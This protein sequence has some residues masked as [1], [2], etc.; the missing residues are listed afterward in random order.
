M[1]TILDR[2]A[3]LMGKVIVP[4][5]L[6]NA[7]DLADAERGYINSEQV[8]SIEVEAMID[9]GAT[10]VCLA[11][12]LIQKL[13]LTIHK[14]VHLDTAEG[15]KTKKVYSN[16][17]LTILGRDCIVSVVEVK[18]KYPAFVGYIALESMDLVVDPKQGKVTFNPEH[19]EE[20]MFD[21]L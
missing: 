15:P 12:E 16:V 17:Q 3:D 20:M 4:I 13:G 5:K 11:P 6:E 14:E 2:K 19:G 7:I 9:T 21:L 10:F 1:T 18:S 8:R